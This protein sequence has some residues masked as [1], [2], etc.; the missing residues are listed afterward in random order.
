MLFAQKKPALYFLTA[1]LFGL[2]VLFG[3]VSY[4]D[5]HRVLIGFISE[6]VKLVLANYLPY[7]VVFL[8]VLSS[9]GALFYRFFPKQTLA[10][11]ALSNI[12]KM[13]Y[14]WLLLNCG[15]TSLAVL[16]LFQIGPVW[17]WGDNTGGLVLYD[18]LVS[19]LVAVA[20]G[21]I[22]LPLLT[23]FGLME[24]VGVHADKW[25]RR[26]FTLPG[27]SAVDAFASW[28]G[29]ST[30]GL[31]VTSN[32]M[33][34][35]FYTQREA[36]VIA[37]NF[38]IVSITF[39][40]VILDT[41]HLASHFYLFFITMIISGGVCALTL[42][43]IPPLSR[44]S[45]AYLKQHQQKDNKPSGSSLHKRAWI[46][47]LERASHTP[48]SKQLINR[49]MANILEV[50]FGVLPVAMFIT[51]LGLCITEY[52]Q[53]FTWLATP[54]TYLLNILQIQQADAAAPAF[55][56]GFIDM[57]LPALVGANIES[58]STRF[59][60]AVIAV[61]QLIFASETAI[62]M[63]KL[64]LPIKILEL[65]VVFVLRTVIILPIAKLSALFFL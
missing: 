53:I 19:I 14:L 9:V 20:L 25:F 48:D 63:L 46:A 47:A 31:I 55:L 50:W 15:G 7:I 23:D 65:V 54:I 44:I 13:N 64:G 37:T 35:G 36:V 27:R 32:Q 11:S 43:R 34:A 2:I 41:L 59:I 61:G 12:F 40:L 21:C 62:M 60:I 24:F 52:T 38:S 33:K 28:F 18:L 58:E 42:P 56:I 3:P 4:N 26:L 10:F 1:S 51:T 8:C 16:V 5:E 49:I 29:G 6:T 22:V 17:L 30:I 57:F 39:T 45:N